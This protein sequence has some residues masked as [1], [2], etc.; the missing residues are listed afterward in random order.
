[1][2]KYLFRKRP[3]DDDEDFEQQ[4]DDL[5]KKVIRFPVFVIA[6]LVLVAIVV[7][8][9]I[10]VN[11]SNNSLRVLVLS[12]AKS[13]ESDGFDYHIEAKIDGVTRMEYDGQMEFDLKESSYIS[14]YHADYVDYEYDNVVYASGH[15][16]YRGNCYGGKWTIE[17]YSAKALDFIDWY[18]DFRHFR[19]DGSSALRFT[20]LTGKFNARQFGNAGNG[21][22]K[23]LSKTKNLHKVLH[24]EI[25]SNDD[26]GMT[27]TYNPDMEK[28]VDIVM[29]D[30]APAFTNANDYLNL[31]ESI[32]LNRENIR[33]SQ[34]VVTYT[35]NKDG[36]L[37][38]FTL[39]Y[40]AGGTNYY[41]NAELSNFSKAKVQVP[42]SFFTAANNIK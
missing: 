30:I 3:F 8:I 28:V 36:Y 22:I 32:E 12:T 34:M 20:E 4:V 41:I 39:D 9:I 42:Q 26:G 6:G 7:G 16:S 5:K 40:T 14:S 31:K 19:F 37:T 25:V 33:N 17:D 13:I 21:I 29:K 35:T 1:M 18:K 11:V 23:E 38:N 2:A 10:W 27:V 24:Q 15:K